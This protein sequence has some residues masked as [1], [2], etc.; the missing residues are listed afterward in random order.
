MSHIQVFNLHIYGSDLE[1]PLDLKKDTSACISID[2]LNGTEEP[3]S[4]EVPSSTNPLIPKEKYKT[5]FSHHILHHC[6]CYSLEFRGLDSRTLQRLACGFDIHPWAANYWLRTQKKDNEGFV[7]LLRTLSSPG[8][9]GFIFLFLLLSLR[10]EAKFL[11]R[12]LTLCWLHM[13][14]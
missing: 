6:S 12:T 5:P 1:L 3:L 8:H 13:S 10:I 11:P 4:K 9:V 14:F 2:I 7:T